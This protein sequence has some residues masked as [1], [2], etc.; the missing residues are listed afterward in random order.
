MQK[1][2]IRWFQQNAAAVFLSI[3]F[4][5][6]YIA[7]EIK[8]EINDMLGS[9][10]LRFINGE[11]Y[12]WFTCAFL[13]Y[14]LYHLLGNIAGLLAVSSLISP[15][16]GKWRTLFFF[17]VGAFLGEITFSW[18]VSSAAPS[19]GG[20]ASG[21]IFALIAALMVCYLRYPEQFKFQWYRADVLIAI[22]Y[23]IIA[24]DNWSSVLTHMFGFSFGVILSFAF[25]VF[26]LIRT[27]CHQNNIGAI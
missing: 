7:K 13:H 21:G 22:I 11:Y 17:F 27:S 20:G 26:K 10:S 4:V 24:N 18:I 8:P 3:A 6:V 12:R 25:V 16:I 23:F 19:Y 14:G 2:Y 5:A 1:K 15:L 9:C